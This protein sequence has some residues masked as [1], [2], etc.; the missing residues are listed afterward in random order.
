MSD[1]A[2]QDRATVVERLNEGQSLEQATADFTSDEYFDAWYGKTLSAL[3]AF[4]G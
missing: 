1:L 4:E 2:A 3:K